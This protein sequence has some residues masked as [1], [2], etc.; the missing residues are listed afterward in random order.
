M[1]LLKKLEQRETWLYATGIGI[2]IFAT[3]TGA[4]KEGTALMTHLG[5][6]TA[7]ASPLLGTGA[8]AHVKRGQQRGEEA[9]AAA[10][11]VAEDRDPPV[12]E[13]EEEGPWD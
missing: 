9:I 1:E 12:L 10:K 5:A 4:E 7:M 13:D 2:T 6:F 3:V 11:K 8:F